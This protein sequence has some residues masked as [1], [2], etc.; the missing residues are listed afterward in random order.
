M[1]EA[2]TTL[3]FERKPSP[4]LAEHRPLYKICQVLLVLRVASRAGRSS[5]PRLHL[6]NWALKRAD[7]VQKLIEAAESGALRVTAWGFD[8][9]LAICLRYAVAE[10]LV[11]TV[12]TGYQLTDTGGALAD[13]VLTRSDLFSR[14]KPLL[15]VIGKHVTE[16]MVEGVAKGWEG[17]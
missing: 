6:F 5:L 2:A 12:S 13:A 9:A 11:T 3:R 14:Q 15:N 8:P 1:A 7:R 16:G 10:G 17:A 4:V